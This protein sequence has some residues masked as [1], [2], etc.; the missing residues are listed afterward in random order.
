MAKECLFL[1]DHRPWHR[2]RWWRRLLPLSVLLQTEICALTCTGRRS[3]S[4][5]WSLCIDDT[6]GLSLL[7]TMPMYTKPWWPCFATT[8]TTY[9]SLKDKKPIGIIEAT[10]IVRYESQNSL[11]LVEVVSSSNKASK[12]SKCSL[13]KWKTTLSVSLTKMPM[14]ICNLQ[15]SVIGRNWRRIVELAEE[16]L[17][18]S[19]IPYCFLALGLY[20]AWWTAAGDRPR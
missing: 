1:A 5:R 8:C 14:L 18:K 6:T 10:D 9:L 13:S 4:I 15:W 7:T 2:W 11:L 19:P 12:I 17:G 3:R 20:G 16:Q